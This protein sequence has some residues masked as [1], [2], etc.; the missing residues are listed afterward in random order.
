G[1]RQTYDWFPKQI[2]FT[3]TAKEVN[4]YIEKYP[5]GRRQDDINALVDDWAKPEG[6]DDDKDKGKNKNSDTDTDKEERLRP[7]NTRVPLEAIFE[8]S[9]EGE[10][11]G[12]SDAQHLSS[13]SNDS[14]VALPDIQEKVASIKSPLNKHRAPGYSSRPGPVVVKQQGGGLLSEGIDLDVVMSILRKLDTQMDSVVQKVKFNEERIEALTKLLQPTPP[15]PSLFDNS[16]P[17]DL[18]SS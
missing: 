10:G 2:Y 11:G 12:D 16:A 1:F 17:R 8:G 7:Q 13:A 4:K 18:P 14:H 5:K 3:A 15:P 9:N 6:D